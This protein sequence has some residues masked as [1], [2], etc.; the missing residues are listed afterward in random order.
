MWPAGRVDQSWCVPSISCSWGICFLY[1]THPRE[2]SEVGVG[3]NVCTGGM[4]EWA[5]MSTCQKPS[6]QC[7]VCLYVSLAFV[8]KVRYP[9]HRAARYRAR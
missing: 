7:E 6:G 3:P 5:E 1:D 2:V 8:C 4:L 9:A